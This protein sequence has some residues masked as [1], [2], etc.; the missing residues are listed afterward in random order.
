MLAIMIA[1]LCWQAS[2]SNNRWFAVVHLIYSRSWNRN[3]VAISLPSFL[4]FWVRSQNIQE[5]KRPFL[6]KKCIDWAVLSLSHSFSKPLHK[7]VLELCVPICSFTFTYALSWCT[8]ASVSHLF[9]NV[10]YLFCITSSH[11]LFSCNLRLESRN[12]IVHLY[13]RSFKLT[14]CLSSQ[15]KR[16]YGTSLR[17]SRRR[18]YQDSWTCWTIVIDYIGP[19]HCYNSL[20]FRNTSSCVVFHAIIVV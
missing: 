11:V 14:G 13:C 2:T 8:P 9:S 3:Q 4:N 5:R 7:S 17:S 19:A 20:S 6:L 10:N 18:N 16:K 15:D 12:E 1:I